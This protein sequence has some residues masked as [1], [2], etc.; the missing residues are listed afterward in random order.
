MLKKINDPSGCTE[1]NVVWGKGSAFKNSS[2]EIAPTG[3]FTCGNDCVFT[4]T[5]ITLRENASLTL[6][7]GCHIRGRIIVE[8]DSH[9][10]IGHGLMCAFFDIKMQAN[11]GA[12]IHVG[13]DCLFSNVEICNSDMHSIFDIATGKRINPARDVRIGDRVWLAAN[14]RVLKGAKISSDTVVGAESVVSGEHPANVI[15][16]GSPAKIVREGIM[17]TRPL[18][19]KLPIQLSNDFSL[20]GFRAAATSFDHETVIQ[21]GFS[22]LSKY[23]ECDIS[24]SFLFYYTARSVYE[25]YYKG[26]NVRIVSVNG[27]IVTLE[28]LHDIFMYVFQV[29]GRSNFPCATYA[30]V[31]AVDLGNTELALALY[32]EVLPQFPGIEKKRCH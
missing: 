32:E 11:E 1:P 24:N 25:I 27:E 19:D 31:S 30:Y 21:Q 9:I 13:N 7:Y 20:A 18:L 4:N 29:S 3:I 17:W 10:V 23:R 6:G 15:L 5:K 14:A 2:M 12:S 22:Y 8:P 26:K 16:A 28:M